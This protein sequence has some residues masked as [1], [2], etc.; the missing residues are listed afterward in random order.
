MASWVPWL[1]IF[2]S[3]AQPLQDEDRRG[4]K[5]DEDKGSSDSD[6]APTTKSAGRFSSK[7][8]REGK[9][10]KGGDSSDGAPS[11]G[12][13]SARKREKDAARVKEETIKP[14]P[15]AA[16]PVKKDGGDAMRN[17]KKKHKAE[18]KDGIAMKG[19]S[20]GEPCLFLVNGTYRTA[21]EVT[22][23]AAR[24]VKDAER[25]A[26]AAE[27]AAEEA[28]V[29]ER[30]AWEAE[31]LANELLEEAERQKMA[32]EVSAQTALNATRAGAQENGPTAKALYV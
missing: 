16:P 1:K 24:A 14:V 6:R 13:R 12:G 20:N 3:F 11:G 9:R 22:R 32:S 17:P 18:T 21:E 5:G 23:D 15:S 27:Q 30:E 10:S 4:K 7:H 31:R 26:A 25:A 19:G 28:E 2:F 8:E 29:C